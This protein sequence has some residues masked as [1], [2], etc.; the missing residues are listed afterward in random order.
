M[1]KTIIYGSDARNRII[2]GIN[3]VENIVGSS[4]GPKGH[5][6]IVYDGGIRPLITK[7]GATIL[8]KVDSEEPFEKIGILLIKDIV[9][10]VDSVAGDGTTTT[11]IYSSELMRE[12]NSLINLGVDA[13]ALRK[14]MD[15]A[16][17]DAINFLKS[18][19]EKI[20]DIESIA[21]IST[22]ENEELSQLLVKAYKSIGENGSIV[23]TDS[24]K[25]NGE[26]YVVV[27]NGL[28]WKGGIPSDLF[29][30][31]TA[32][33]TAVIE[34]PSIM[35]L[36]TGVKD[37]EPLKPYIDIARKLNRNLVFVA[38]YFEPVLWSQAAGAGVFLVMSPGTSLD[39]TTLHEALSDFAVVVGTKVVTSTEN[40]INEVPDFEKDLGKAKLIVSSVKETKV[41][42]LDEIDPS[43]AKQY[44]DYINKLKNSIEDDETTPTVIENLKDRLARLSGGIAEIH[45][46]A[47]TPIEREEKA[48]LLVDAQNS[49]ASALK[50]GVLPGGG[51]ALLKTSYYLSKNLK[52]KEEFKDEAFKK[53][54]EAVL[55]CLKVPAQKLVSSVKPNDYQYI[56]Q[57]VAHE[58]DFW[59]GYNVRK[60]KVNNL[61]EDKVFDSAAIELFA[62]EYSNSVIG[63]FVIS[64]GVIVN[65][66]DNIRYD[67][68]DRSALER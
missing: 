7:D 60:E 46:G 10:K 18:K 62:L 19:A 15:T 67:V 29:I 34:N 26:S 63:S 50:Y 48:A 59:N 33:D 6:V 16:T 32:D 14:G 37:L 17:K 5:N 25:R 8:N 31:N 64:D 66:I 51:T 1:N 23:L 41:T 49:V 28:N 13:N 20:D 53:G 57:Q 55:K 47:L 65:S 58:K 9:S 54:Y 61:K 4:L 38:P 22:N 36:A 30:T 43:K 44:E 56:V 68:N 21:R 42:Q 11:T 39:H 40:A 35:V 45:V 3:K 27:S 52:D 2:K 24:Y 12:V